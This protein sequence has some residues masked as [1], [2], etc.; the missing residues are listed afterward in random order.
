MTGVSADWTT[1]EAR[2]SL[3]T[4]AGVLVL[5]RGSGTSAGDGARNCGGFGGGGGRGGVCVLCCS[6]AVCALGGIVIVGRRGRVLVLSSS[7]LFSADVFREDS[8]VDGRASVT[9]MTTALDALGGLII[10]NSGRPAG[11]LVVYLVLN[12]RTGKCFFSEAIGRSCGTA[13]AAIAR[14]EDGGSLLILLKPLSTAN[15]TRDR[16]IGMRFSL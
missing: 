12:L 16:S 2:L 4:R 15:H 8:D 9:A 5:E 14:G 3:R 10:S 6:A 13:S 7:E 1:V 11:G